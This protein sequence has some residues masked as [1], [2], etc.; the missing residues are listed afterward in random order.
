MTSKDKPSRLT[1]PLNPMPADISELLHLRG[2]AKAYDLRPPYQ[3]NDYLGW[4]ARARRP[5]TRA[6][7]IT[8]ML[9]ELDKG[10][11]YIKMPYNGPTGPDS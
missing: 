9:D 1:R 11:S 5:E 2:V 6:K 8:Q 3:G 4:I 7:R 10:T